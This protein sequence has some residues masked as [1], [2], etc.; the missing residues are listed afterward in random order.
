MAT[1]DLFD[2]E[3]IGGVIKGEPAPHGINVGSNVFFMEPAVVSNRS[4]QAGGSRRRRKT[5]A[6]Q[7]RSRNVF[8]LNLRSTI[9]LRSRSRSRSHRRH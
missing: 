8:K 1:A 9:R 4:K 7:S 5:R 2:V 3:K 6:T